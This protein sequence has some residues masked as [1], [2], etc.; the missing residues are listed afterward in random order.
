MSY[1]VLY[2][3]IIVVSAI[4]IACITGWVVCGLYSRKPNRSMLLL[5]LREGMGDELEGLVRFYCASLHWDL[6]Q[7][8]SVIILLDLGADQNTLGV[9]NILASQCDDV[10]LTT[11]EKLQELLTDDAVYKSIRLILY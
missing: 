1:A 10:I 7:R 3:I 4:G 9:A 2:I 5:P 6:W 11:P 8:N